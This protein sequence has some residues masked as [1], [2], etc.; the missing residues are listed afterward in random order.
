MT[1]NQEV[2]DFLSSYPKEVCENAR[3]LREVLLE[4]LPGIVEQ[5]DL[6]AKMIA[7]GYGQK[8]SELICVIIPSTKGLKLG[9]NKGTDLPD[10]ENLLEGTGKMSRYI[11]LKSEDQI[12]SQAIKQLLENALEAF[13]LRKKSE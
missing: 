6:P 10:P 12:T 1:A 3:T 5:I 7:Y 8:Y 11:I 13:R 9:F 2:I 4:N